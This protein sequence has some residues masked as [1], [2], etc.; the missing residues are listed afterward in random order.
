MI[1]K[2]FFDDRIL[3]IQGANMPL[4]NAD[5][6]LNLEGTESSMILS[7][8]LDAF[9]EN[10]KTSFLCLRSANLENTW[11]SFASLFNEIEAAGGLVSNAAGELLMIFRNGKWDLPKGK[12]DA[13]E[14]PE[15]ASLREVEEECG[16]NELVLDKLVATVYHTYQQKEK[17][18]LKKTYWYKMTTSHKGSLT[19]QL[20][21]GITE[22]KWMARRDMIVAM[23]NTWASIR[24]LL[25]STYLN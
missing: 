19:P 10:T 6:V 21:E 13:G 2:I 15:S 23:E 17:H 20:E 3:L 5:L 7:R 4:P 9:R 8:I 24:D 14:S 18:Y 25:K 11:V 22:V 16:L 12:L 1:Y